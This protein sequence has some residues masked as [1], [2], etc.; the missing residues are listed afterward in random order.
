MFQHVCVILFTGEEWGSLGRE[1]SPGRENPAGQGDP[2]P[3]RENPPGRE[4]PPGQGDTPPAG[5]PPQARRPPGRENPPPQYGQWAAGTHPTGMHSCYSSFQ[6]QVAILHCPLGGE[7]KLT[8]S[9][10]KNSRNDQ[11]SDEV[12]SILTFTK[13]TRPR[14]NNVNLTELQL[15]AQDQINAINST[16]FV[17]VCGNEVRL[18]WWTRVKFLVQRKTNLGH[19]L[20]VELIWMWQSK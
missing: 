20:L 5:R 12:T 6:P 19:S 16:N 8:K 4:T 14:E 18:C 17:T 11:Q 7:R 10:L 15:R 1:N 3:S 9:F 13:R 2:P